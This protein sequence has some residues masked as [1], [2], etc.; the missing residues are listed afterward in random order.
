MTAWKQKCIELVEQWGGDID[1]RGKHNLH[2]RHIEACCSYYAPE[3]YVVG[4][5]RFESLLLDPY[6]WKGNYEFLLEEFNAFFH[7][8]TPAEAKFKEENYYFCAEEDM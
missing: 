5:E 6:D 2:G 4:E 1:R 7:K 3:G 8:M